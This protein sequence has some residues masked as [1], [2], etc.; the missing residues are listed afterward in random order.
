VVVALT[1]SPDGEGLI[2]R[3]ARL[4]ARSGGDLLA[5]H[6]A[7]PGSPPGTDQAALITPPQLVRSAGGTY[8]EFCDDDIPAALLVFAQAENAT[9]LVLGATHRSWRSVLLPM[10]T[11]P[12]RVLCGVAGI[13]VHIVTRT[14][15]TTGNP[16][17]I[18]VAE[19][20]AEISADQ[21]AWVISRLVR[22]SAASWAT[23]SSLTVSASR[24]ASRAR[25]GLAPAAPV[26]T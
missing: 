5:V 24:P 18:P 2:R 7:R 3:A 13:D 14:Q 21:R 8:H 15:T 6:V 20:R 19:P 11:I 12:S 25:R 10:S 17:T 26:S 22:P 1:G 16:P 23:L 9:L 4:A